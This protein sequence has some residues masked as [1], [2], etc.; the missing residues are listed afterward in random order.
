MLLTSVGGRELIL[1]LFILK[2]ELLKVRKRRSLRWGLGFGESGK[3]LKEEKTKS[4]Y[5][6]EKSEK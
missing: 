3:R 6:E 1:F 2:R 5:R 4:E